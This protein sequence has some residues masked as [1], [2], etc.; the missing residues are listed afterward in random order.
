[1]QSG[2]KTKLHVLCHTKRSKAPRYCIT[3]QIRMKFNAGQQEKPVG[4]VQT[5]EGM[6]R[7]HVQSLRHAKKRVL[8]TDYDPFPFLDV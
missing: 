5:T 3:D 4:T 6:Q 8:C 7:L 1:M 2:Q